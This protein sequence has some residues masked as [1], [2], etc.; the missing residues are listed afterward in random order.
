VDDAC[1]STGV[2]AAATDTF[3]ELEAGGASA[4]AAPFSLR[5]ARRTG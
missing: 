2:E 5:D 3:A 4:V 1:E